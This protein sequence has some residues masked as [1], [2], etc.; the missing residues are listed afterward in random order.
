MALTTTTLNGAVVVDTNNITVASATGFAS[1]NYLIVDHEVM[2]V[3][4]GY[5]SGTLI[6]VLRGRNGTATTAHPTAARVTTGL[7]SDFSSYEAQA[8]TNWPITTPGRRRTSISVTGALPLPLGGDDLDVFLNGTT[9]IAATLANPTN[10]MDGSRLTV[11]GNGKAAHTVTY[12]AG[13]GNVG[14]TADVITFG[15]NQAQALQ[16]VAAGGFWVLLGPA[17][18][19]TANVSG[20]SIA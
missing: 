7:G 9:I 17:A 5:V 4:Q 19:A 20:P 2:Q 18:T 3:Q 6:P 12:T 13:F 16:M 11:I 1:G 8:T 10:D 15:A 14:G